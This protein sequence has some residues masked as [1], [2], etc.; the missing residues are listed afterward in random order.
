MRIAIDARS[1][2]DRRSGVGNTLAALLRHLVPL[3]GDV[4]FLLLRHPR[5]RFPIVTHERVTELRFAGET[6]SLQTVFRLGR[7]HDFADCDLYYSP[8]DLV[9]FVPD[10]QLLTLHRHARALLF[11]SHYEGFGLP[12][13][14]AMAL[15]TPVLGSTAPAVLAVTGEAALHA[16]ASSH[17]DMVDKMRRLEHDEALRAGLVEAGRARVRQLRWERAARELLAVFR[18]AVARSSA[19]R[20]PT[21]RVGAPAVAA[22]AP[23][24]WRP[25]DVPRDG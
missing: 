17:R 9:P 21:R 25:R 18:S 1:V 8:A 20:G 13:L 3:A 7:A 10:E 5:S 14:Y 23:R 19:C 4:R 16:E 24:P 6:K 12:A 22:S 15:G 2:V 11:V